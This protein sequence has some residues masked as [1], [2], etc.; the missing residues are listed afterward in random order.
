MA[1]KSILYYN[2]QITEITLYEGERKNLPMFSKD[3]KIFRGVDN[4]LHFELKNS[5]RQPVNMSGNNLKCIIINPYNQEL[6]LTKYLVDENVVKGKYVLKLTPG[7]IQEWS[8]GFYIFSIVYQNVDGTEEMLYTTLDQDVSGRLEIVDKPFPAFVPAHLIKAE[9]WQ[10][11]NNDTN[12]ITNQNFWVTSKFAGDAQKD[13]SDGLQTFS[14][15]LNNFSGNFFVQGSLE[16]QIITEDD[17]FNISL[18]CDSDFITYTNASGISVF[19]FE[20]NYVWLR[21]RYQPLPYQTGSITKIWLK[22]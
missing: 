5:D 9:D 16:D 4:K 13:Y 1:N 19:N 10:K 21:F 18:D 14:I 22:N 11:I 15:L 17:W 8:A 3:L 12:I 7:D 20:G 6:M 2:P